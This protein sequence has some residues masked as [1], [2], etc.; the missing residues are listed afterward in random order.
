MRFFE[1]LVVV[2][3]VLFIVGMALAFYFFYNVSTFANEGEVFLKEFSTEL[4][5]RWDISDVYPMLSNELVKNLD[6]GDG[7]NTF[8]NLKALGKV[9]SVSD[10]KFDRLY[11]GNRGDFSEVSFRA[12]F[13]NGHGVFNV[14]LIKNEVF[15]IRNLHV[16]LPNGLPRLVSRKEILK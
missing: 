3:G 6:E 10:F 4:S 11:V 16:S 9:K 12:E 15:K 5:E 1:R 14:S 8:E 2:L 7:R 13:K